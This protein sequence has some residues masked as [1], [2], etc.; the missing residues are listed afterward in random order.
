METLE[1]MDQ[2]LEMYN[3][4]KLNHKE[5]ENINKPISIMKLNQE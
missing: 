1:E 4:L 3:L 2:L 5:T